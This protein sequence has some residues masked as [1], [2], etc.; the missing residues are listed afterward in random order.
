VLNDLQRLN[1]DSLTLTY[2]E[3]G[4]VKQMP[5]RIK[6][7][8]SSLRGYSIV[9]DGLPESEKPFHASASEALGMEILLRQK[10]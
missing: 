2:W 9:R 6:V 8:Y 4:S 1:G 5:I 10:P 3:Y 7:L